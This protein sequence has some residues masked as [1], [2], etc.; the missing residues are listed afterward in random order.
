MM[1]AGDRVMCVD[2]NWLSFLPEYAWCGE[3]HPVLGG[4]YT[5]RGI[6]KTGGCL[7][8]GIVNPLGDSGEECGFLQSHFRKLDDIPDKAPALV[9]EECVE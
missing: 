8:G 5:I 9:L 1:K 3:E 6:R 7:L 4:V 2:V